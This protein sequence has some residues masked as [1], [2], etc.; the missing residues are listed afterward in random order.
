[1]RRRRRKCRTARKHARSDERSLERPS[2][3]ERSSLK[4]ERKSFPSISNR[5]KATAFTSIECAEIET[6]SSRAVGGPPADSRPFR[7]WRPIWHRKE[8][9]G[10]ASDC[11]RATRRNSLR[12]RELPTD[13]APIRAPFRSTDSSAQRFVRFAEIKSALVHA[14]VQPQTIDQSTAKGGN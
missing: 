14:E 12:F 7:K 8:A 10:V 1:M 2:L 13:W 6:R 4:C 11:R 9:S 3:D 5:S